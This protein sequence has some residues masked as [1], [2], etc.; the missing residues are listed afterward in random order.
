MSV[1]AAGL[2]EFS[3]FLPRISTSFIHRPRLHQLLDESSALIFLTAPHGYGKT[4]L[5]VSWLEKLESQSSHT[6]LHWWDGSRF[7]RPLT[8]AQKCQ[9]LYQNLLEERKSTVV[10]IDRFDEVATDADE[11]LLK[12]AR[13]FRSLRIIISMQNARRVSTWHA[14]DL[15]PQL[16]TGAHLRFTREETRNLHEKFAVAPTTQVD[17]VHEAVGGWPVLVHAAAAGR[18]VKSAT[19]YLRDKLH[20]SDAHNE[21]VDFINK[22]NC[23]VDFTRAHAKYLSENT[24][25]ETLIAE[26][27][28]LG[29]LTEIVGLDDKTRYSYIDVISG[30]VTGPSEAGNRETVAQL[31]RWCAANEDYSSAIRLFEHIDSWEEIDSILQKHW[32]RITEDPEVQRILENIKSTVIQ[33]FPL[34][35]TIKDIISGPQ[36]RSGRIPPGLKRAPATG[37]KDLFQAWVHAGFLRFNG[38]F[39]ESSREFSD[40]RAELENATLHNAEELGTAATIHLQIALSDLFTDNLEAASQQAIQAYRLASEAQL[41]SIERNA[42]GVLALCAL[43]S[44][45]GPGV[46]TWL[47]RETAI[48]RTEGFLDEMIE[49]AGL[50][51]GALKH[52]G[53][54]E[55]AEARALIS[56]CNDVTV[57]DEMWPFIAYAKAEYALLTGSWAQGLRDVEAAITAHPETYVPGTLSFTLLSAARSNLLLAVGE[58][59]RAQAELANADT[60]HPMIRAVQARSALLR[61]EY[62]EVIVI[63]RRSSE[64]EQV[65]DRAARELRLLAATAKFQLGDIQDS[66]RLIAQ[67]LED[68]GA[69]MLRALALMP[70]TLLNQVKTK[71]NVSQK[72]LKIVQSRVPTPLFDVPITSVTLTPRENMVLQL[73]QQ[74]LSIPEVAEKLVV[75]TNTVKSQARSVYRKLGVNS[76]AE[77]L[78]RAA[79]YGLLS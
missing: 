5:L 39:T 60:N 25:T 27:C 33:D 20:L 18:G 65:H 9:S 46:D 36:R 17:Q 29:V 72:A 61:G 56:Q 75:S 58:G 55:I 50:V 28:N 3:E 76:R 78:A 13:E 79:E 48:E 45:N 2:D 14:Y 1:D 51:A 6:S 41:A 22:T 23:G 8:L 77:A 47:A 35:A 44:G 70:Q 34:L 66:S 42:A 12:L 11:M 68:D 10:V 19:D 32:Y 53:A 37:I 26:L 4:T 38:K 16:I 43:F 54:L 49:T 62:T 7:K 31:A 15:N 67:F 59:T 69:G 21:F 57:M 64:H 52:L 40:I 63:A 73:L 74:G 71:T 30:F 24:D